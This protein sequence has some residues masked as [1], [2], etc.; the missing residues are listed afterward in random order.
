[1]SYIPPLDREIKDFYRNHADAVYQGCCFLTGGQAD[2]AALTKD[3][4]LKLLGKGLEFSSDKDA[5]AWMLMAAMK[6]SKKAKPAPQQ[7]NVPQEKPEEAREE[8]PVVEEIPIPAEGRDPM[9]GVRLLSRKSRLTALLY[10][11]EG[12][13]KAEVASYLG[14][15]G[16]AVSSRL[17]K[18][19]KQFPE[20]S[21]M[22]RRDIREAYRVSKPTLEQKEEILNAI[23]A[24]KPSFEGIRGK[25]WK[26]RGQLPSW[27]AIFL[28]IAL[29]LGAAW[30]GLDRFGWLDMAASRLKSMYNQL[31]EPTQS[32]TQPQESTDP[33]PESAETEPIDPEALYA[34]LVATYVTAIREGWSFDRCD[35]EHISTLVAFLEK[36][37]QL[38]YALVDLDGDGVQELLISDGTVIY[39]MYCLDGGEIRHVF[40]GAERN[41]FGLTKDM[42]LLNTASNSAASTIYSFYRY[43]GGNLILYDQLVYDGAKDPENPWF[44]GF[45]LTPVTEEEAHTILQSY[46]ITSMNLP[47]I[48]EYPQK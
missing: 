23:L 30:Y 7:N 36:P 33:L 40:T 26:P 5:R 22:I 35:R 16:P 31:T 18:I 11:C 39:D 44:Q 6:L 38:R 4:F 2:T 43:F 17:R 15:T 34:P 48:D 25:K 14:C 9:A 24:E 20:E 8:A 41:S 3:V 42:M 45:S 10:Y 47:P 46:E 19:Q 29:I 27:I 13:R 32:Q 21:G 12:Y 1:M 28:V 37:G